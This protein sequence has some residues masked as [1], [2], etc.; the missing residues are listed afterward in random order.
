MV[1]LRCVL[2]VRPLIFEE[3][4]TY[5]PPVTRP[6]RLRMGLSAPIAR[7][8]HVIGQGYP[9]VGVYRNQSA[10]TEQTVSISRPKVP[11]TE[12]RPRSHGQRKWLENRAY[13][14]IE[15]RWI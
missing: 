1:G 2:C 4:S 3:F 13:P 14:R 9:M 6:Q 7:K 12:A 10:V 11:T 15:G 8:A 5:C